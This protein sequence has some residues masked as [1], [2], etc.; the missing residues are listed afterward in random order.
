VLNKEID[1]CLLTIMEMEK[2]NEDLQR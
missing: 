2:Y 1:K